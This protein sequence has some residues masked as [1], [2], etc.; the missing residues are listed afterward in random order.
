M[1]NADEYM[2]HFWEDYGAVYNTTLNQ[3]MGFLRFVVATEDSS[4][5]ITIKTAH[6]S[7]LIAHLKGLQVLIFE[8]N[9]KTVE[10]LTA[11]S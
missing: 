10:K 11:D 4:N 6:D 8:I 9:N 7:Q 5:S 3:V 1:I 2:V